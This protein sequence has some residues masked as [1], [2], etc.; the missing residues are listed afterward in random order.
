VEKS[1]D[2]FPTPLGNPA[3]PAGF[4]LSHSL[5]DY[6]RLTKTG[7]FNVEAAVDTCMAVP[8][9][10]LGQPKG[11]S[12]YGQMVF[13]CCGGS[14]RIAMVGA[15]QTKTSQDLTESWDVR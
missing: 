7:H 15:V 2:D 12:G 14:S 1:K 11:W 13:R 10:D 5:S 4:P 9:P 6:G 3:N 8:G